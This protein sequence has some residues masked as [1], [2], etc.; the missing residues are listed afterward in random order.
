MTVAL[1]ACSPATEA[2]SL[3]DLILQTL[4]RMLQIEALTV[5]QSREALIL[6]LRGQQIG[7]R[8][9][10]LCFRDVDFDL[11]GLFVQRHEQVALMHPVVIVHQNA[12]H[13]TGNARR[14]EGDMT[15]HVSVVGGDGF[16]R[17][18]DPGS[19]HIES[20]RDEHAT[21]EPHPERALRRRGFRLMRFAWRLPIGRLRRDYRLWNRFSGRTV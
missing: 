10:N 17:E 1:A 5:R 18:D 9:S 6:G 3:G 11:I 13:V 16:E 19:R 12:H 8:N 14:D 21:R 7:L 2:C 4:D 20:Y 15:V